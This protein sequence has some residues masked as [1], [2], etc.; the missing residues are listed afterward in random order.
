MQLSLLV[1]LVAALAISENSPREPVSS[2]AL[3]AYL[4]LG[5]CTALVL[6]TAA[7]SRAVTR[8]IERDRDHRL[9]WLHA[10]TRLKQIHLLAWLTLAGTTLF[11]LNWTQLVRYNWGFDQCIFFKDV[12]VLMPVWLP[13]LLSWMVFYDMDRAVNGALTCGLAE[14]ASDAREPF[15]SRPAY[16]WLH[17]RHYLGLS[18]LPALFLLT[19]QD[20]AFRLAPE[21]QDTPA[22]WLVCL[23][24][25]AAL[26]I[27]FPQLL[28]RIWKTKSLPAGPLRERLEQLCQRMRVRCRDFRIWQTDRQIL[29]AAVAGVIPSLRT[30]YMTDALLLYLRDEELEA[31]IAHELGH[32]SRRHLLLRLLLLGLPLW[33]IG[34]FQALASPSTSMPAV[35]QSVAAAEPSTTMHM[36]MA[37]A[38]LAMVIMALGWYSRLLEHDADLCVHDAGYAE[39]CVTTIDRLAYLCHDRRQRATWLHPSTVSRVDLLRHAMHDESVARRFRRRVQYVNWLLVIIWLLAPLTAAALG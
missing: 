6:L 25:L 35:W 3:R 22:A 21:W 30:V 38:L 10:A 4:A 15:A 14:D 26:T 31:V 32:V 36:L 13:L 9:M 17:A 33:I 8:A 19:C 2:A 1:A 34:S 5:G 24:P 7:G 20:I 11:V 29:N 37:G 12:L 27:I 39:S 18:F 16:V 23:V 28:S